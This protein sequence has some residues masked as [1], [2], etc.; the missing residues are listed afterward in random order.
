MSEEWKIQTVHELDVEGRRDRG[1]PCV[2]FSDGANK[3]SKARSL[4][5][6]DENLRC[7]NREK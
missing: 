6:R 7:I 4:E 5:L 2:K 3:A 1:M